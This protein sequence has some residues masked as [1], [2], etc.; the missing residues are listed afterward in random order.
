MPVRPYG[1]L[2]GVVVDVKR[3][4][5]HD[6][7][8]HYQ[9]HVV[10]N[11]GIN[12]RVAVNVRSQEEPSEL[13]YLVDENFDASKLGEMPAGGSGWTEL[14]SDEGGAALDYLR[15]NLF[16]KGSMR[17]LPSEIGGPDNDLAD[18]FD[19][20]VRGAM[21]DRSVVIYVFGERWGPESKRDKVFHFEPGNG[22]HNVH[23][24]QGNVRRFRGDDGIWQDGGVLLHLTREE[25][26]VAVFLAFQSQV[27][28][29]D[30]DG[31]AVPGVPPGPFATHV[32]GMA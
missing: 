19:H 29:T 18:I 32:H 7:T 10:D 12:Y 25:R 2:S 8:P 3:E 17:T 14:R 6:D 20:Y 11:N 4:G 22:V 15:G 5:G 21:G 9:V 1:V 24:N 16:D 13:L 31:H 30:E 28:Q 27:W 23:L 26:W